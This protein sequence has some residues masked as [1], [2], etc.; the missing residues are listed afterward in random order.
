MS[1]ETSK[2]YLNFFLVEH[3]DRVDGQDVLKA[4][5]QR[6]HLRFDSLDESIVDHRSTRDENV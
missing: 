6:T 5:P 3:S 4:F 1:E 2:S